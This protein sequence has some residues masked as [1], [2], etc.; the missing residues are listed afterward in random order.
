[1]FQSFFVVNHWQIATS[2]HT[3]DL[4]SCRVLKKGLEDSDAL[5]VR[6]FCFRKCTDICILL[7]HADKQRFPRDS[8]PF[9]ALYQYM[10]TPGDGKNIEV[11]CLN[12]AQLDVYRGD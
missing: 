9:Q 6:V 8:F 11:A 12:S 5:L 2:E 7:L 3:S 1:M 4:T 10:S